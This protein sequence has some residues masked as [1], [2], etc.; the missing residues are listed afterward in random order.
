MRANK[1]RVVCADAVRFGG[2]MGNISRGG[3]TLFCATW[4][5][6]N[7]MQQWAGMPYGIYSQSRRR[8]K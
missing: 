4:K 5:L 1:K 3:A 8:E 2:G 6:F 7:V